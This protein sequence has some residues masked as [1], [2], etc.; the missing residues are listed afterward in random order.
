M[1]IIRSKYRGSDEYRLTYETLLVTARHYDEIMYRKIGE[2][3][4]VPLSGHHIAQ[5]V[6]QVLAEISEDEFEAG[7]PL[8]GAIAVSI[9]GLP[10]RGF[11]TL[12]RT[13]GLLGSSEFVDEWTFWHAEE[14][15]V[16]DFWNWT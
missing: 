5:E 11:F 4:A 13:L 9:N 8:L 14:S 10:G 7:R 1:A 12:A 6:G 15:K 2:L 16:Y 3:I